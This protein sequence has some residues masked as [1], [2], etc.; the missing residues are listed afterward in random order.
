M[1][2]KL[3]LQLSMTFE[4]GLFHLRT[5]IT[6]GMIWFVCLHGVLFALLCFIVALILWQ[7]R[8]RLR[9]KEE[10]RKQTVELELQ[11]TR[12]RAA[13]RA[14]S[15]FMSRMSHEIRTPLNAIIG[16]LQ[17]I[18]GAPQQDK[19]AEY[20][21]LME[22]NS[23]H[24]MGVINDI[25]DFSK[26]ESGRL[27]LNE[28]CFSLRR[29]IEFLASMFKERAEEKGLTLHTELVDITHDGILADQ[30]R[31]NQVLINLLSNAVKFTDSGGAVMLTAEELVHLDGESAYRFTVQDNGIGIAPE[32]AQKL[33]TPFMQ[34]NADVTRLYGGTGLGL[35]ISQSLVRMMGGDIELDTQLGLGAAFQFTIRVKVVENAPQE[36]AATTNLPNK[37]RGK[38]LLIVDDIE[39][40]RE[41]MAAILDGN[42]V[43]IDM[44]ADGQ[45]ALEAFCAD[46]PYRYDLIFMDMLMPVM[47]GC[48]ATEKIRASGRADA[49]DVKIIAMTANVMPE[50]ME[51]A[52]RAGMNG[53]L[54]KPIQL[55]VLCARLE[56]WL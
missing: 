26:I 6:I 37:L 32:Q 16:M 27:I 24:L 50:D 56:E 45:Q 9:M 38:H 19:T 51:R 3:H 52:Y 42:D 17:I 1:P 55:E 33:F 28:Q 13:A 23:K 20:L 14:K 4:L 49:E 40:N 48:T 41:I 44:A 2:A 53:Y 21:E 11:V 43:E 35:A 36:R 46:E 8:A 10:L 39:I 30:L 18:R 22:D 12:A 7:R 15:D 29:D 31:L 34:A 25:L 5:S 54:P 47:D